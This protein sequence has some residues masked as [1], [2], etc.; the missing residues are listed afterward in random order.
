ML[1]DYA[2]MD[3]PTRDQLESAFGSA[4]SAADP[5]RAVSAVLAHDDGVVTV[6]GRRVGEYRPDQITIVGIGKASPSMADAVS[7]ITGSTSGVVVT[8]YGTE[9]AL[10]VLRGGH[11]VPTQASLDAGDALKALVTATPDDG[12]IVAVIS[13]G[14]SASVDV[15]ADGVTLADVVSLNAAML[16]AGMPIE[17]INEV[18]AA[19][20]ELKAGGVAVWAGAT[21]IV[22]LVLSDVVVGGPEFV[23]SG[24]TIPSDLGM[25]ARRAIDKWGLAD[26]LSEAAHTAIGSWTETELSGHAMV[27]LVGSPAMAAEAA[28]L[29][30]SDHGFEVRIATAELAGEA[31]VRASDLLADTV[32]GVVWVAA[33]EPT[34][35]LTGHGV[36]GRSQEAALAAASVLERTGGIFAALGTDGVDGPT[37]AA[38]AVVDAATADAIERAGWD[39]DEE[40]AA[41][42][43]HPVL[44]DVGCTVV[45][46]PTGTNVCDVWM[47][48]TPPSR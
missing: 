29:S 18:R 46:G 1:Q 11:P 15:L 10:Q 20:S 33:G 24:P 26:G 22:S 12:L 21:P 34:V 40:L 3:M 16:A 42:N 27:E 37:R 19:M 36:G 14:G 31:S 38:G 2:F 48:W 13:G 35:T 30:L 43:S 44:T 28:A 7:A 25:H 4:V 17:D 6:A 8:P 9:C 41:N 32:H 45:T 5:Y 47:W 23:S 39:L